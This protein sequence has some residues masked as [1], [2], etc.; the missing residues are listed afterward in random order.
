MQ[1]VT[2]EWIREKVAEIKAISDG[3][4]PGQDEEQAHIKEDKLWESVLRHIVKVGPHGDKCTELAK[5]ALM[6][7]EVIGGK[8]YA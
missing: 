2:I 8:W 5:E 3:E 4:V 1:N 6:A 7:E